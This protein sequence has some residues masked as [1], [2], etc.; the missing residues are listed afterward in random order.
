MMPDAGHMRPF[1]GK[2]PELF[3]GILIL[4][5]I[6]SFAAFFLGGHPERAWQAYLI[7]FLFWS[8]ISQG[9][10]VFSAVMHLTRARWS[11]AMAGVAESFSAF[12]PISFFLY[13]GLFAG[14]THI[15]PWLEM[16]LHGKEAWLNLPFLF[17]RDGLGLVIL[18]VLGFAYVRCAMAVKLGGVPGPGKMERRMTVLAVLYILAFTLVLSLLGYDLVM[19]AD[20]HW[21]STLFGGYTFVKAFYVGLGGVIIL[22]AA[23]HLGSGEKS[24]FEKKQF[25]DTGKLFLAFC[26]LWADFFYCQFVVIWY[27]NISEETAYVIER[28]MRAPYSVLAWTVFSVCFLLPFLVLLNR[29]VKMMPKAMIVLCSVVLVGIW[30]E[31]LLLLGPALNGH[32]ETLPLGIWDA[33]VFLGFLGVMMLALSLFPGRYPG[34]VAAPTAPAEKENR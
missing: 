5:G 13:L 4:L 17:T 15:F 3:S 12:F 33:G 31:H 32:G 28:T 9:A 18:Y 16:D 22:A 21:Y 8:A 30:L 20:P 7:N 11:G 25:L 6:V 24:P 26:L 23:L 14:R 10:L 29:K 19:A 2:R 27:G 34:T 1:P